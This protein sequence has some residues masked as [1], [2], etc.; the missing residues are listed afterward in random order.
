V[1]VVVD[2]DAGYADTWTDEDEA[3]AVAEANALYERE[4]AQRATV[5]LVGAV[6][7]LA[8]PPAVRPIQRRWWF[9][10]G[11]WLVIIALAVGT[12]RLVG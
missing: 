7:P 12:Y 10:A 5:V 4:Q 8:P 1:P 2:D 6:A 11:W 3:L 9:H